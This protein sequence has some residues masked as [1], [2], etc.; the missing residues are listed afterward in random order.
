MKIAKITK[1]LPIALALALSFTSVQAAVVEG[2]DESTQATLNYQLT[3]NDYIKITS[4]HPATTLTSAG[5]FDEDYANLT[6]TDSMTSG[7]T[8]ISNAENRTLKLTA[9]NTAASTPSAMYGFNNGSFYLVFT[10]ASATGGVAASS[11]TNITA[12]G[13]GETDVSLNPNAIAF[14]VTATER[15]SGGP[16]A[17]ESVKPFVSSWET[18]HIEY[19]MMNGTAEVEFKVNSKAEQQ[20]FSTH[21]TKGNYQATLTLT[22]ESH[23]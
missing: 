7:F 6:L 22:D 13:E 11:V 20:T 14:K 10:N 16:E 21:D 17:S 1:L 8:I 9:T 3:L 18:D 23:T 19:A 4:T 2:D 12:P 5:T 15:H